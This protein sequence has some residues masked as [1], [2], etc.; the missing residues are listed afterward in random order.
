[1]VA[2]R[3]VVAGAVALVVIAIGVAVSRVPRTPVT[4]IASNTV[5]SLA[6]VAAMDSSDTTRRWLER[7]IAMEVE[8]ALRNV[9]GL[10]VVSATTTARVPRR[11]LAELLNVGSTLET[12]LTGG[13]NLELHA[14]LRGESDSTLF[15]RDYATSPED[16]IEAEDAIATDVAN[17]LRAQVGL[18]AIARLRSGT[19]SRAAHEY[20]MRA[21]VLRERGDAVSLRA[22]ASLLDSA[23]RLASNYAEAFAARAMTYSSAG[24]YARAANDARRAIALDS[25]S[26][27]PHVVLADADWSRRET[28]DAERE[29]RAAIRLDPQL[30][31]AR[32]RYALMLFELGR[33]DEAIR[34]ARRAHELDPLSADLHA[35]YIQM[36]T[37]A[38][39]QVEANHELAELQR[40]RA[41]LEPSKA[42]PPVRKR[43]DHGKKTSRGRPRGSVRD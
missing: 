19:R 31:M 4:V 25:T 14:T 8:R 20:A 11:R 15:N 35:A 10:R 9:S 41:I 30:A 37:R 29:Y 18:P 22:A 28:T 42:R 2:R 6:I 43:T 39:R 7:G 5:R 1:M 16:L 34:E 38:G 3:A 17:T 26:A 33:R 40:I 36:L 13:P 12:R 32:H 24:D 27:E 23:V 21:L